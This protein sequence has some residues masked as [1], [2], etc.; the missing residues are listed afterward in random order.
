MR[1]IVKVKFNATK[2]RLEKFGLNKYLLYLSHKEDNESNMIII[3]FL[4]KNFG[5]PPN[6]INFWGFDP[7][8]DRIFE[9]L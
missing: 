7:H 2:E 1:V 5:V 4:S 6:K 8:K 3:S 9:V